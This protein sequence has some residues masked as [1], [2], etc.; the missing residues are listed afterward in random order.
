[1]TLVLALLKLSA[2]LAITLAV[3]T[4]GRRR[5]A[6]W[7][8]WILAS[9]TGCALLL[10]ALT[11][12]VPAWPVIASPAPAPSGVQTTATIVGVETPDR[13]EGTSSRPS[14]PAFQGAANV[15]AGVWLAGAAAGMCSLFAGVWRLSRVASGARLVE[16]QWAGHVCVISSMLGLQRTV[17]FRETTEPALLV[18]WGARRAEVL[19]PAGAASWHAPRIRVVVAH[20]LAHV[21]RGDWAIQLLGELLRVVYWFHPLAWLVCGQLRHESER[22]CDDVVLGLGIA[23]TVYA[24]QLVELAR[25]FSVRRSAPLPALAIAHPSTLQR[26][27]RAMLNLQLDRRPLSLVS[28]LCGTLV[29]LL[30]AAPIA[31]IGGQAGATVSGTVTDPAG[32]PIPGVHLTLA[33]PSQDFKVLATTDASGTFEVPVI[34]GTY[35]LEARHPGFAMQTQR[36]TLAAGDH[37]DQSVVLSIGSLRETITVTGGPASDAPAP[38]PSPRRAQRPIQQCTPSSAGGQLVP[39]LKILD[40]RPVYPAG[41]TL[42]ATLTVPL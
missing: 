12:V 11:L 35:Q 29:I 41:G 36:V 40:V 3:A 17:R 2:V 8:H 16:G 27:I 25:S 32:R 42:A 15:L 19:L 10:P 7:R 31:A 26:R 1:M 6:A 30:A 34:A 39:P 37:V 20:E 33:N 14:S 28:R 24:A 18:T 21:R 23:R 13:S 4:L 9:G 5:S 38:S 22:A